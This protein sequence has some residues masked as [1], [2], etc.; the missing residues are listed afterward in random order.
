MELLG[1]IPLCWLLVNV[2]QLGAIGAAI[3]TSSAHGFLMCFMLYQAKMQGSLSCSA[4]EKACEIAWIQGGMAYLY[5]PSPSGAPC[6]ASWCP[7]Y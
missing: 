6:Y 4:P 2:C 1:F 5:P 7:A 3:A